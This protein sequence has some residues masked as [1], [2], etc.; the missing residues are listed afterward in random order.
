MTGPLS[1]RLPPGHVSPSSRGEGPHVQRCRPQGAY[2]DGGQ[3]GGSAFTFGST[4]PLKLN[5]SEVS[6]GDE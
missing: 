6:N 4:E 2:I 5:K 3:K 1:P